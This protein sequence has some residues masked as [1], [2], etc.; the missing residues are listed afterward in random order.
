MLG[1][2]RI[3]GN[4]FS[5]ILRKIDS[6]NAVIVLALRVIVVI[7]VGNIFIPGGGVMEKM[8]MKFEWPA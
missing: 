5:V 7:V 3:I 8:Q 4:F 6:P 1:S 2:E